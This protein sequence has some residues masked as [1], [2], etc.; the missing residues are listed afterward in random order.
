M[1]GHRAERLFAEGRENLLTTED[2][3]ALKDKGA[4]KEAKFEE[5]RKM[6]CINKSVLILAEEAGLFYCRR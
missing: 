5:A 1:A 3:A 4:G 2:I 6:E